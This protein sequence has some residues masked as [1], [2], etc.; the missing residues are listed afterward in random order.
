MQLV[1]IIG[2][3][4]FRR[5]DNVQIWRQLS[6]DI[7]RHLPILINVRCVVLIEIDYVLYGAYLVQPIV[8]HSDCIIG[9]VG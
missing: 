7:A 3:K 6:S 5:L 9:I 1:L 8:G 4:E 2:M